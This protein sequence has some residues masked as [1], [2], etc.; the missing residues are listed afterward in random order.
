MIRV[1]P[2]NN[3]LYIVKRAQIKGIEN[4]S[5]RWET[6]MILILLTYEFGKID[7]IIKKVR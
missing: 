4:L 6:L 2:N 1:L 5:S 3:N 7:K